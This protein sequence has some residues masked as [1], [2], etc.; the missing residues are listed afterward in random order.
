MLDSVKEICSTFDSGKKS[1]KGFNKI[2][3]ASHIFKHEI[4]QTAH[5]LTSVSGLD[6]EMLVE[7]YRKI[8]LDRKAQEDD[9]WRAFEDF[10]ANLS[11]PR[12]A[13]PRLEKSRRIAS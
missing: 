9:F 6:N 7:A 2:H 11:D 4:E 3:M 10:K 12:R 5:D 1:F 8:K 13:L